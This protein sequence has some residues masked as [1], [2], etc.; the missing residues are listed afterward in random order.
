MS[1]RI[2]PSVMNIDSRV[3]LVLD[4]EEDGLV[5]DFVELLLRKF[6]GLLLAEGLHDPGGPGPTS[7]YGYGEQVFIRH[8]LFSSRLCGASIKLAEEIIAHVG[9]GGRARGSG[10]SCRVTGM[11]KGGGWGFVE[12]KWFL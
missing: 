8:V 7:D 3:L 10:F 4:G 6:A 2:S 12:G 5:G 11:T 1:R 9:W